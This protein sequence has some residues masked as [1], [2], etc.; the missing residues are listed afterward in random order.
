P[1]AALFNPNSSKITALSGLN[2]SVSTVLCDQSTNRVYVGGDFSRDNSLNA[3]VWTPGYGWTDLS[4]DGFNGPV[5][6]IIKD[7][8]DHIIFGG[9]FTGLGNS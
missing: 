2:G 4:F 5:T 1:G 7:D 3:A 9:S 6:S 8:N